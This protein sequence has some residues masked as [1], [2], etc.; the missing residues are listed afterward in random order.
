MTP[1]VVARQVRET[2]LDYLRTTFALADEGFDK[3]LFDFLDGEEGLFKG[4]FV[5]VRL[6]FRKADAGERIPLDIK[7]DFAPY[8]HQLTSF[9]RLYSRD[10][11]QPQHTLVTTGTGSGKTECFLYPILDHCWREREEPGIK[12][13]L[14]YPMNAL[15]SDQAR[16]LAALLHDDERLRGKVS[17]GLYVGGQGRHG[18]ADREHLIDQ[19]EVLRASPPDILLTNYKML[20][21]LLLRPEDRGLWQHNQADT[22]RY[23][24]LDELHTYDGAQGSDVACLIRRLKSR[25][26]C[27]PGSLCCVGTSATVGESKEETLQKLT[28]FAGKVFEADIFPDAVV[29]EDRYDAVEALGETTDIDRMPSP[30][31]REQLEPQSFDSPDAWLSR[32]AQLWLGD[33]GAELDPVEIGKRLARHEFLRKLLRVLDGGLRSWEEIDQG[34]ERRVVGWE[35]YDQPTRWSMLD[36]FLA[37]V[38]HARQ[39]EGDGP[40]RPFLTVQVQLWVRELRE[41]VGRVQEAEQ[42]LRFGWASE[43]TAQSDDAGRWLRPAHC[44]E[45]G[46]AGLAAAQREGDDRLLDDL[47]LVGS[48]WLHRQR[49][50]RYVQLGRGNAGELFGTF[51]CPAC[52]RFGA[53]ETCECGAPRARALIDGTL[54]DAKPPRFLGRCPDCGADSALSILGSRAPSLQSVAISQLF[55]SEYNRD[56]KLLAFTDSVQ[57][58]CHRAGFFGART[59]RFNLRTAIQG[60]LDAGGADL[61]LSEAAARIFEYWSQSEPAAKLIATLLPADLRQ[62][63]EYEGFIEKGGGGSMTV[64]RRKLLERLAWEVTMEYGLSVRA[65]RTLEKSYCSTLRFDEERVNRAVELIDLELRD[66]AP[67]D[68]LP[69]DAIDRRLLR[70]FVRGLLERMR[71]R[72]G[73]DHPFLRGYAGS[74]GNWYFLTKRK[75]PLCSPFGRQSVMPR[76]LIDRPARTGGDEVFD[77]IVSTPRQPTWMR[78]WAAKCLGVDSRDEGVNELYRIVARRLADSGVLVRHDVSKNKGTSAWALDPKALAVTSSVSSVHCPSCSRSFFLPE[79]VAGEWGG[80]LCPQYRCGGTLEGGSDEGRDT[81]YRRIYRSGRLERIFAHEHTGLLQRDERE[82]LEE[83]FKNASSPGAPNLF[84]CTPTLEMGIDIGDLSS[85]MMCSVPPATANYLQRVGRAGRK[86]GNAFGMTLALARPHDLYFHAEPKEIMAGQV[87]PPGCFLDAPEMLKR[88]LVAHG[89]DLWASE[90]GDAS[91][92]PARASFVLGAAKK[93]DFP[94]AFIQYFEEN[95]GRVLE[96]FAERFGELISAGNRERIDGFAMNDAAAAVR[97]A[98]DD[99]K[100]EREE[101][102]AIQRKARDRIK[103]IEADPEK[104]E[105]PEEEKADAEETRRLVSRLIDEIGAKYP[106][107][108]LTDAGVLPNYAFPEPGV[109]L[110]SVVGHKGDDGKKHYTSYEFIRPA[111]SAIKE[112][113]PFNTFYADGRHVRVDEI[114]LGTKARPLTE[115]WRLCP[116]CSHAEKEVESGFAAQQCPRCDNPGWCDAGQERTLVRFV[117]SRSL[118][119]LLEASAVDQSDDREQ[120]SYQTLDLIDVGPENYNGAFLAESLPFG[121]ELLKDLELREINFGRAMGGSDGGIHVGGTPVSE[122]GFEVC[123]DCGRVRE[124]DTINHLGHCRAKKPDRKEKIDS[125]YLYRSIESEAIRILL[126]VSEH[127]VDSKRASFKAALQLGLRRHFQG[128]PGHLQV[129]TMQEPAAGGGHRNFLVVF[130]AVPG[131][132]GYLSEIWRK[133]NFLEILEKARAAI[134]SCVCRRDPEKDGC[135]RCVYAYQSQRDLTLISAKEALNTLGTI[136]GRREELESVDT[137]SDATVD[138]LL[139][140]ELERRFLETLEKIAEDRAGWSWSEKIESGEK[141]WTLSVPNQRWEIRAQVDFGSSDAEIAC[142]PDFVF[143][144][145]DGN[146]AVRPLAVFCDGFAFHACPD[147]PRGRIA[148]DIEKRRGIL[149]R[150][151]HFVWA[152][153]W[154][155][156]DDWLKDREPAFDPFLGDAHSTKVGQVAQTQELGALK[157]STALLGSL[158]ML[159]EYLVIPDHRAWNALARSWSLGWLATGP[160][161]DMGA[162]ETFEESLET[163]LKRFEPGPN[164]LATKP[165]AV[166]SRRFWSGWLGGVAACSQLD[167]RKGGADRARVLLRL[168]DEW[169]ARSSSD[170]EQSWRTMLHA[171]NLL[172][173]HDRTRVRSSEL[174]EATPLAAA[175]AVETE[176]ATAA[177][178]PS[179]WSEV[180]DLVSSRSRS[181]LEAIQRAG[182]PMPSVDFELEVAGAGCGPEPELAWPD[183]KLAL[184]ADRQDEDR[185]LFEAAGWR[186]V[187]HP[188]DADRLIALLR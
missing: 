32:Q 109:T 43:R 85:V 33:D 95:R 186:V 10:G 139:E 75:N 158:E 69:I 57:D 77:P 51:L 132:T 184:I 177:D 14:L 168:F 154:R 3:A 27:A 50:A 107:N 178:Q 11:H 15:A 96:S 54:S 188:V 23:V 135:Y 131:G 120:E 17:A 1:S 68:G 161:L 163:R 115:K 62:L 171:W 169:E 130:D 112:L 159:I 100:S 125:V 84:V 89:M 82:R 60:A 153:T 113:A 6:P 80:M 124:D 5:D 25:L 20:D 91:R 156:I 61:P 103:E 67:V 46:G 117:R 97:K 12:A 7:P 149:N 63:P 55:S 172:Q 106:L 116:A 150:G 59:Y 146:P 38:S 180:A 56:A 183:R 86:T 24:V 140:S 127:E 162:A 157:K 129:K 134:E 123:V 137:L 155:D 164:G 31:D 78:D 16:R 8:K 176:L 35:E 58:A 93:N 170:F 142:R 26:S 182:L 81:Y 36:S 30:A 102:R 145:A 18:V 72:G 53:N 88:Q 90:C 73:I 64:L 45:C 147:Q 152:I 21:F 40:E 133:D 141:R 187:S 128:D 173:F 143:R 49:I 87:L 92:I 138:Q 4:P 2:I 126:P 37:L 94:E 111:S 70:H 52:L 99:L 79:D 66:N 174:L 44:R 34:L 19:R 165:P 29:T 160:F 101:L 121:Y 71:V 76:F 28:E 119:N 9:R 148:D 136:L 104:F 118:A 166:L 22:L 47:S 39:R 181:L 114:D 167:L 179:P 144:P 151:T 122:T 41:L 42:G 13:I 65:G 48:A 175:T 185:E 110:R 108:V 83:E 105:E 98:F 74:G